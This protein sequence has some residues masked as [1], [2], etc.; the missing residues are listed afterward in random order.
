MR[1]TRQ[2]RTDWTLVFAIIGGLT[3]AIVLLLAGP[4]R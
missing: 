2:A 1:F 4:G 3:A